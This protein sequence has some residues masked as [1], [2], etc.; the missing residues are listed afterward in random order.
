MKEGVRGKYYANDEEMKNAV[1]WIKEQNFTRLGYIPLFKGDI[2][3][4]R[5]TV[6][7]LR[8]RDVIHRE[9]ASF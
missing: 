5:E 6:T 3:L 9:P 8:R 7:M 2:S 4:L 1:K